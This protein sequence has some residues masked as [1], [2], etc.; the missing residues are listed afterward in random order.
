MIKQIYRDEGI[1]GFFKG[2]TM[3]VVLTINP[4]I[5]FIIYETLKRR[6]GANRITGLNIILISLISKLIAT[7]FTYPMLTLKTLFQA[8]VKLSTEELIKI[9]YEM[10]QK[11]GINGFYKGSYI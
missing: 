8:N 7:I 11:E 3:A 10:L 1:G 5:S 2:V 9:L 4:I 6:M